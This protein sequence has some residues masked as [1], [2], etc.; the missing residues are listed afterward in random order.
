MEIPVGNPHGFTSINQFTM[1][2][3]RSNSPPQQP[4]AA[5]VVEGM[6]LDRGCPRGAQQILK[7]LWFLVVNSG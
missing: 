7:D 1:P 5:Q 4:S 3:F 6:Q 2:F